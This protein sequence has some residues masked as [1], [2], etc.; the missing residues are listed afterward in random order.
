ME[1]AANACDYGELSQDNFKFIKALLYDTAGINIP[2]HKQQMV[3]NRIVKRIQGL[4]IG[5]FDEYLTYVGRHDDE[6]INLVNALTTNVTHFFRETHH[7]DH[8]HKELTAMK[9]EGQTKFRIWSA[10]CSI[11][12]EPYSAAMVVNEALPHQSGFD[13]K[14]LAT[15]IDTNALA[16]AREGVYAQRLTKGLPDPYSK[17]YFEKLQM[18]EPCLKIKPSI[19]Q[20]VFYNY[21]NFNTP[22]WPVSGPFDFIFCRNVLIYFDKIKQ[23]EYVTKLIHLLRPG[24]FLYLGHSEN[25][26]MVDHNLKISGPTIYQKI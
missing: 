21:L 3:F 7:F 22:V 26:V 2:D 24:G 5:S 23:Q 14:I 13:V 6:I 18:D 17:K 11:G 12:A 1:E 9:T 20:K 25:S 4:N 15:D 8:L 10:A 16:F 19:R